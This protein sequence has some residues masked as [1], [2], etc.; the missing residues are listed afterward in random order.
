MLRE[1]RKGPYS[2][3]RS[4]IVRD[5]SNTRTDASIASYSPVAFDRY[6]V[7]YNRWDIDASPCPLAV[8]DALRRRFLC[9]FSHPRQK[10]I[11]KNASI[12]MMMRYGGLSPR[13]APLTQYLTDSHK[14]RRVG[15]L[16]SSLNR[17]GPSLARWRWL[18]GF[19]LGMVGR[20][21]ADHQGSRQ[22]EFFC[23]LQVAWP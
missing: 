7:C 18:H 16:S 22:R 5:D 15:K 17:F 13:R 11:R 21:R 19:G 23:R 2:L 1:S 4:G 9:I 14:R 6:L 10:I 8:R 12:S 20:F 3:L